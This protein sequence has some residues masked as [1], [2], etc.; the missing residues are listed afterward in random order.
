MTYQ[1]LRRKFQ[2]MIL[3]NKQFPVPSPFCI[4]KKKIKAIVLGCDPSN[5]IK[6]N[7]VVKLRTV[8]GIGTGDHRYF[9]DILNNLKEVGLNFENIYV[10][11]VIP[12]Y[13][14]K[15]TS[16]NKL[17]NDIAELVLPDLITEL[18]S[19]DS[20]RKIPVFMTSEVI[21]KFLL[22]NKKDYN[23]PK[24][25]YNIKEYLPVKKE[26]NKLG[27]KLFPLYRHFH[28]SLATDRFKNYKNLLKSELKI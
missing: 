17:W 11:N 10:Q 23:K 24:D 6:E 20:K 4:N 21:Y 1:N 5:H 14:D 18:D 2:D 16:E 15:E 3:D 25:L 19:I 12:Y 13:M 22:L 8:F 28:Y 9:R 27:R 7:E 26:N